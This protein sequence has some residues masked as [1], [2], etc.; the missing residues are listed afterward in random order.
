M[1]DKVMVEV[2]D[3]VE[4]NEAAPVTVAEAS[5]TG[6]SAKE[7]EMGKGNG[8][9]TEAADDKKPVDDAKKD[10]EKKDDAKPDDKKD[11]AKKEPTDAEREASELAAMA[12]PA[13]EKE[14]VK[15]Y[16]PNEKALYFKHKKERL[17]R[18]EAER[19]ADFLELQNKALKLENE[20]KN[21][22]KLTEDEQLAADLEALETEGKEKKDDKD[23][24]L[25][26]A[27][28]EKREAD[29]KAKQD[30]ANTAA[31]AINERIQVCEAE[32]Q[33]K[34]DDFDAMMDL[35]KEVMQGDKHGV[36]AVKLSLIAADPEGN[37]AE[38]A[39]S[40]GKLHPNYGKHR[41]EK[42]PDPN[43]GGAKTDV[44]K[45]VENAEKRSSSAALGGGS[46]KGRLVSE[47]DLTIADVANMSQSAFDKLSDKSRQRL[48]R[49]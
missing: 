31:R 28:L 25:T 32:A 37:P 10:D 8:V 24:P 44:K 20:K 13:K 22:G 40:L 7:L 49:S 42:Q 30:E 27:D 5:A 46:Q 36:F 4:T 21:K 11:D 6:L 34:Y 15:A 1:A 16:N 3:K 29:K 33:A 18:Q 2:V 19:R 9:L 43:A 17:K 47:E 41:K 14:L 35:A 45:I 23:K 26:I 48:L 39:Y 38:Y 12:D